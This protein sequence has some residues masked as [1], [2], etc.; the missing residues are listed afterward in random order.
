MSQQQ[1]RLQYLFRQFCNDTGTPDEIREFWALLADMKEDDP[2]K[3]D[4][5]QLWD[6]LDVSDQP[7]K[8]DWET[9]LQTIHYRAAEWENK[10]PALSRLHP[11]RRIAAAACV[12]LLLGLGSY[13]LFIHQPR[14]AK[15][16]GTTQQQFK[17]DVP[18]GSNGATLTLANGK[19]IVLDSAGNG[20]I[21]TQG[22]GEISNQNGQITYTGKENMS[23]EM[24]YNTM[25]TTRG[26]QYKVLLSD[27]SAAWLNAASS[28][29]Y[30][31]SFNGEERR[32]EITGEVYFEI[33]KNARKPFVVTA[34]NMEVRV[35]GTHFN[36]NA[37]SD[38]AA[39]ATTL[40]EGS[41][42]VTNKKTSVLLIPGQQAEV[43]TDGSM[44]LIK[45]ADVGAA[46]A[47]K[48]GYFSFDSTDI[49]T[50]MRQLSRWYDIDVSYEGNRT[51][52]EIFWGDLPRNSS[53][54]AILK[55][56]EKTGIQF[57]IDGKK[58]VVLSGH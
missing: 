10:Q 45:K 55:A 5:F 22:N 37:Y 15:L 18:P 39:A 47:W 27:G 30:P 21:A 42:K 29:R 33:A 12:I 8:K 7:E 31:A 11:L 48:A 43:K 40:L 32:V 28:I 2:I 52:P 57:T 49:A 58:V 35:L 19:R 46:I 20:I 6:A 25:S 23:T 16:A 17:N 54:S 4:I 51:P 41:V 38:E 44:D 36:V 56:L 26:R 24:L 14:Q 1:D 3:K 34:G 13:I 9:T 50:V 53:L